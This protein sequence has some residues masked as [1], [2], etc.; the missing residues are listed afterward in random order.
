LGVFLVASAATKQS[1]VLQEKNTLVVSA[2]SKVP[3]DPSAAQTIPPIE[4][5]SVTV[6][7]PSILYPPIGDAQAA[8]GIAGL[9]SFSEKEEKTILLKGQTES[10]VGQMAKI[11]VQNEQITEI[12]AITD[13]DNSAGHELLSII[14]KY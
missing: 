6:D 5:T 12:K 7:A 1:F 2:P 13:I 14:S 4:V 10:I 8:T 11:P 3:T 9:A